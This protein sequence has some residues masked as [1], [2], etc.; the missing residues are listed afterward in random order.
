[1]ASKRKR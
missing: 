1:M